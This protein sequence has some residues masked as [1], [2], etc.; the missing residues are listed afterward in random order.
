M[1]LDRLVQRVYAQLLR[2]ASMQK[3]WGDV[4]FGTAG[5]RSKPV[6]F[7]SDT[8]EE[9][10]SYEALRRH[11]DDNTPINQEDALSILSAEETG[12]YDDVLHP[13]AGHWVFRGISLDREHMEKMLGRRLTPEEAEVGDDLRSAPVPG[14][15]GARPGDYHSSAWTEDFQAALEFADA[16]WVDNFSVVLVAPI[17]PNEDSLLDGP[18]GLYDVPG[19]DNHEVENETVAIGGLRGVVAVWQVKYPRG[20][21][22]FSV[23]S[24]EAVLDAAA[25]A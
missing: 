5:R 3:P 12:L 16:H 21:N 15:V 19:L 18:G 9:A 23:R 20:R 17:A 4:A 10:E 24:E 25:G 7:E 13:P 14:M 22:E 6:D 2:E 1:K 11:F 8:P